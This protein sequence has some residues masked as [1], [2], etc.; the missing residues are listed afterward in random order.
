MF[1]TAAMCKE[2]FLGHIAVFT[3]SS[4]QFLIL[5]FSRHLSLNQMKDCKKVTIQWWHQYVQSL[6]RSWKAAPIRWGASAKILLGYVFKAICLSSCQ[7]NDTHTKHSAMAYEPFCRG[8]V[9]VNWGKL[10][11][12]GMTQSHSP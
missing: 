12:F 1:T 8:E 3:V 4:G 6:S 11:I 7:E 10:I 2:S 5:F 9:W